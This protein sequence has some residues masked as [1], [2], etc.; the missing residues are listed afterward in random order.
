MKDFDNVVHKQYC[1]NHIVCYLYAKLCFGGVLTI[2]YLHTEY[3]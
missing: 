3:R 2:L 1:N